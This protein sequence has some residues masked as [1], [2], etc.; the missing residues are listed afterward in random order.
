[1][2]GICMCV[3]QSTCEYH[4]TCFD[5]YKPCSFVNYRPV[6]AAVTESQG[7]GSLNSKRLFLQALGAGGDW[8]TCL[9]GFW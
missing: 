9:V 4:S 6:L 1:M 5:N 7:L 8:G 3:V 2:A